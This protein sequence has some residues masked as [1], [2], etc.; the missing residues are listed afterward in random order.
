MCVADEVMEG[1]DAH[2][3]NEDAPGIPETFDEGRGY[4]HERLIVGVRCTTDSGRIGARVA[5]TFSCYAMA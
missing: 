5:S 1:Q 4:K 2:E 3:Q